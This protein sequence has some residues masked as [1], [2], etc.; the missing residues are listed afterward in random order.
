MRKLSW[1]LVFFLASLS[2]AAGHDRV[3]WHRSYFVALGIDASLSVGGDL[4]GKGFIRSDKES[5]RGIFLP[6]IG[7]FPLP[8]AEIGVN[9]N[10][11]AIAVSFGM[12]NID[13]SYGKGSEYETGN[14]A[15]YWRFAAEYRYYFFWK[16]DF[17]VGPGLGYSFSRLSVHSAA[18]AEDKYSGE[19]REAAVFAANGFALSANMRYKIRP[20]GMDIALRYRPMFIRSVSTDSE[21]YNSLSE[22][23]WHHNIEIGGKVFYEF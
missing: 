18:I 5:N 12:W 21:G 9:F 1:I 4:D 15:N 10:Q 7:S 14:D 13:V 16:E 11:H 17:Q 22:T 8:L 20:F 19:F 6:D 3:I 23:L 2:F